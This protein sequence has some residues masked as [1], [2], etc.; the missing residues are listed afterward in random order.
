M[1]ST[2]DSQLSASFFARA[3]RTLRPSHQHSNTSATL[4]LMAAVM[5]S[6]VIG[7][8]R[9]AYIAWAFGVVSRNLQICVGPELGLVCKVRPVCYKCP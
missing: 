4:L 7:Y 2:Q 6:R 5:L 3:L 1:P 9:E 8:V